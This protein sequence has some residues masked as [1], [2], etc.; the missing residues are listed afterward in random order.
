[1]KKLIIATLLLSVAISGI[2]QK[3]Q[4]KKSK[5]PTDIKVIA[6]KEDWSKLDFTSRAN[7][8]FMVQY[9]YD[10]WT[11]TNDT[12]SPSGFSR[13]F[14]FYVMLDK[15]FKTNPH[16]S[17]GYGLGI[18]S[19]NIF[20]KDRYV[21]LKAISNALPFN[22]VSQSDQNRFK[23]FKLVTTYLEIPLELRYVKDPIHPDKGFKASVGVKLG[24]LLSAYSKAKNEID[25]NGKTIYGSNYIRKESDQRF[26]NSTRVAFTGRIGLGFISL[27]ASYQVTGFLKS[28]TG[29]IINP[30]SIGLTLSGL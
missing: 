20:F 18:G 9:G 30:Y 27:D 19:S 8:H 29:P 12:T 26:I 2:A 15:P 25:K 17:L 5:G 11:G 16:Y 13:H 23:K 1:M 7:D 6:P 28:G 10:G 14:N 4:I 22:D 3:K 21:D 24:Y